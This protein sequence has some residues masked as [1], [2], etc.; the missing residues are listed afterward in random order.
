MHR[1]FLESI[2]QNDQLE[3]ALFVDLEQGVFEAYTA[4][5]TS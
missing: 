5:E 3:S 4:Q 2:R 1:T